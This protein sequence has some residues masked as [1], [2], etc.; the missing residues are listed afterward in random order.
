MNSET[1]SIDELARLV[2]T[3]C[4]AFDTGDIETAVAC[5]TE[6]A[7]LSTAS[8]EAQRSDGRPHDASFRAGGKPIVGRDAIRQYLVGSRQRR[9]GLGWQPRHL[10]T[11]LYVTARSAGEVSVQSYVT[12]LVTQSDG[13]TFVDHA[14]MMLEKI[15]REPSG[16][17][18]KEHRISIDSDQNFPGRPPARI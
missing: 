10:V 16:W 9:A 8:A 12:F 17:K 11:N 18:F 6:D 2:Y 1:V 14:G 4:T 15:V 7:I 3:Y 13:A 5:F